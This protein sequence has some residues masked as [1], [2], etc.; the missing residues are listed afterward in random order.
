M[1]Q[2]KKG[3]IL[4]YITIILTNVV[5]LI[6]TPFI[7]TK[8]GDAEYGLYTLIGAFVGYISV[9]DLGLNNTIVRFV[10][11]YRAEKD[12]I[13]E[14][15]FL[16]TT[17]LIY[18][19]IATI[20]SI[21]GVVMYFNIEYVFSSSLTLQEI[22]KAKIMF[23]ILI[24]NLAITLPGGAFTAICSGYE[25]FVYPRTVN[26][27]RYIVRSIMVVA[28]L[29]IGEDAIGLV[30][31]DTIMNLLVILFNG[32]YVF[33]KLKVVFKV[34]KFEFFLVKEIFAYSIW[35]FIF[36]LV[37]QFQWKVG[38]V[39]LGTLTNTTTVAIY[40]IGIMLGTYYGAFSTAVSSVFLPRA[41]KM[42]V[43]ES[44][45]EELTLMMIKIGRI[46][47]LVL[48]LILGGF[49]FFGEDFVNLWIGDKYKD[50]W[51]IALVIMLGY[52]VALVQSFAHL[53]LEAKSKFSFKAIVYIFF[54][55]LGTLLG[56][57]LVKDYGVKGMVV[58]TTIGWV[59]S[60]IIM[61]YYYYKV[62]K[63]KIGLFFLKLASKI[64][65]TFILI[66]A[67]SYFITF[68]TIDGW[69]GLILKVVCFLIIYSALIFHLGM[70]QSEKE[71]VKNILPF[72]NR[73]KNV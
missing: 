29:T 12:K 21:I 11:K 67:L 22:E 65:P 24:F 35:I 68:I 40:A 46:S 73:K 66:M 3:A 55:S 50:S 34:D 2:L 43:N 9:L 37:N 59:I 49:I 72:F 23:V 28:L 48:L 52:T 45:A 39:V 1:S 18:M 6:L 16:G 69:K 10:A 42:I 51:F 71:I 62:I 64:I 4:S 26:I 63:L 15:N 58:G 30:I 20:I 38:Q 53:I 41:T 54:L 7:I 32:F 31:L 36:A 44:S 33:K 60:Q 27:I 70:N 14:E 19:V 56:A 61:N 13:G 47:L 8:L 57:F 5:G 25:H 17:M